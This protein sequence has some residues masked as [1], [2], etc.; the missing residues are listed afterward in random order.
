MVLEGNKKNG[1]EPFPTTLRQ[2]KDFE[3]IKKPQPELFKLRLG[4]DGIIEGT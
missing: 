2:G 3:A 1:P 4:L